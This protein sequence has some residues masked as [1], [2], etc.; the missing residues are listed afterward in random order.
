MNV[1][2]WVAIAGLAYGVLSDSIGANRKVKE[3][4]VPGYLI[5]RF[6]RLAGIKEKPQELSEVVAERPNYARLIE[7][8]HHQKTRLLKQPDVESV[9]AALMG[10][11]IV[12]TVIRRKE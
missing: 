3:N 4:S 7:L 12:L 9:E 2:D 1:R 8:A 10:G 11:Q 6:K 5:A